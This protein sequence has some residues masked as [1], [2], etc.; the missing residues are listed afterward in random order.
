MYV[1]Y[2]I[3]KIACG[4]L[5]FFSCFF[6]SL[7]YICLHSSL[8]VI[9]SSYFKAIKQALGRGHKNTIYQPGQCDLLKLYI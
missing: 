8:L 9:S 4:M 7:V 1:K 3:A 2:K 6:V 5:T